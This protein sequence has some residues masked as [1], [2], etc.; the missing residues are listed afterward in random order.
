MQRPALITVIAVFHLILG[1][2]GLGCCGVVTAA[3]PALDSMVESVR[4]Q[5]PKQAAEM[6]KNFSQSLP[7]EK[8]PAS[9]PV[10]LGFYAGS[11]VLSLFLIVAGFGLLG[12]KS[13]ARSLS[14][15]YAVLSILL[16]LGLLAFDVFY[17]MPALGAGPPPVNPVGEVV[18]AVI[19]LIYPIAVLCV[20]FNPSVAAAFRGE[21]TPDYS[22]SPPGPDDYHDRYDPP[23]GQRY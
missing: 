12:V 2:I 21:G 5:D 1:F 11:T 15:L 6:E 20:M 22:S 16:T 7:F 17:L 4:Q 9:K 8:V 18:Q 19:F 13:W 23:G 3:L 10:W 14:I